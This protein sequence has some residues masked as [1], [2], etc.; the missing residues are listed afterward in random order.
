MSQLDED[1]VCQLL[2]FDGDTG[3]LLRQGA[4]IVRFERGSRVRTVVFPR[5]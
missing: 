1:G 5:R 4:T 2:A 3:V